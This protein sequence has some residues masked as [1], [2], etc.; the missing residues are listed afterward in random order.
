MA[1]F[2]EPVEYKI[3][4][5]VQSVRT[6]V[7]ELDQSNT[8]IDSRHDVPRRRALSKRISFRQCEKQ[9]VSGFHVASLPIFTCLLVLFIGA[10]LGSTQFCYCSIYLGTCRHAKFVLPV[11]QPFGSDELTENPYHIEVSYPQTGR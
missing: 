8:P 5:H 7:T 2:P 10:V 9:G 3:V 4:R 1:S 11:A 6:Y